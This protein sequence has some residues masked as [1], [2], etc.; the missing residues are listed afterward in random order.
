M[1]A[2]PSMFVCADHAAG[3]TYM[4]VSVFV[5]VCLC[6]HTMQQ[7]EVSNLATYTFVYACILVCLCVRAGYSTICLCVHSQFLCEG[8]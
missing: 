7:Q 2:D 8:V 5:W 4:F 6:V 3:P 1:C